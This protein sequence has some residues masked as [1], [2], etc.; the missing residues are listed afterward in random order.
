MMK[1]AFDS[2]IVNCALQILF[3]DLED[4]GIGKTQKIGHMRRW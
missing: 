3:D 4:A 2:K 1:V